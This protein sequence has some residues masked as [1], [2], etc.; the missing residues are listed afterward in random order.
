MLTKAWESLCSHYCKTFGISGVDLFGADS[1]SR[2]CYRGRRGRP[3]SAYPALMVSATLPFLLLASQRVTEMSIDQVA[4]FLQL[5]EWDM[6]EA[7]AAAESR[8]AIDSVFAESFEHFLES[9]KGNEREQAR[10]VKDHVAMTYQEIGAEM[11]LCWQRIQQIEKRALRKI[12]NNPEAI[13][14]LME[15]M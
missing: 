1:Q 15:A 2:A 5:D 7:T 4:D 6:L 11:G 9:L 12:R 8:L 13:T 14:A 3:R 10:T